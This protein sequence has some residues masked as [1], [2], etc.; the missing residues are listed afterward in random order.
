MVDFGGK[1]ELSAKEPIS[2]VLVGGSV[3]ELHHPAVA[4]VED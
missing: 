2:G 1:P 4:Q 3:P